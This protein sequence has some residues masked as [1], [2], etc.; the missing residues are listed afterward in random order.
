M[1]PFT[2]I[3][4]LELQHFITYLVT[5]CWAFIYQLTVV[6]DGGRVM[7]NHVSSVNRV[8]IGSG[9]GLSP[10]QHQGITWTNYDWLSMGPVET[11][12]SEMW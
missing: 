3:R 7:H 4:P 8:I 2:K 12:L 6:R 10:M 1:M 5:L 9:N 11:S